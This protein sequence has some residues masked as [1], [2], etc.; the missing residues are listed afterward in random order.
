MSADRTTLYGGV[1]TTLQKSVDEGVTWTT[2]K[3]FSETIYG[4]RE[5]ANGELLVSLYSDGAAPGT[6]WLSANYPVLGAAAT[7]TKVLTC[8]GDNANYISGGWGMSSYK[9]IVVASE[10]GTT[11]TPTNA[12]KVYL[13][14][15]SGV[16]WSTILDL[17][18]VNGLHVH[19]SAYDP[20]WDAIWVTTGDTVTNRALRVSWDRGANWTVVASGTAVTQSTGILP[21][22]RAILFLTDGPTNGVHRIPRTV[23]RSISAPVVAYAIDASALTTYVG[24]TPFQASGPDMPALLPF[25][26]ESGPGLILS[27]YDGYRFTNIWTDT[28]SYTLKG[29]HAVFGPTTGR[30]YVGR[31][32]DDRQA[33]YSR[34]TLPASP[35][36]AGDELVAGA[37]A[38]LDSERNTIPRI[39]AARTLGLSK[40]KCPLGLC[41]LYDDTATTGV[42][43]LVVQAGAGQSTTTLQE[44]QT[45]G[46]TVLSKVGASGAIYAVGFG[47]GN[48]GFLALSS[49]TSISGPADGGFSRYGV[50]VAEVTSGATGKPAGFRLGTLTAVV[51]T[52]PGAPTVT[53]TCTGTCVSTWSYTCES[54]SGDS[55]TTLPGAAGSTAVNAS[56]LDST[57]YNTV[58]CPADATVTFRTIRRSVSGGTPATL[59]ALATCTSI[60]GLSCVDNGLVGDASAAPTGN[61]TGSVVGKIET[62]TSAAV[63]CT[64]GAIWS[65]VGALYVCTASGVVKKVAIATW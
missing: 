37:P 60:A 54:L 62:P 47:L 24:A 50:G 35:L 48:T 32:A 3:T 2:I 5:L 23:D 65:D 40:L 52:T 44:W 25:L 33:N 7:W 31:L 20:W 45:S 63:T 4:V 12:G 49:T 1:Q 21:L 16:T 22:P 17:T 19:G 61:T 53:P 46:G 42:T 41:T 38:L 11:V 26:A 55:K 51:L 6:L 58:V 59:G 57:H 10:Y 13:S 30:N 28:V 64:A 36:I 18:A 27:T 15:N 39:A 14:T 9:V 8:G 34:L 29:P 56:T 43:K